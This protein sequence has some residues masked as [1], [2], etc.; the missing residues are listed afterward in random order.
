[1]GPPYVP[2]GKKYHKT[3][4]LTFNNAVGQGQGM[5]PTY[6]PQGRTKSFSTCFKDLLT[7]YFDNFLAQPQIIQQPGYSVPPGMTMGQFGGQQALAPQN[8]P[9]GNY[10][11]RQKIRF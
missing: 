9:P 3:F 4:G 6:V 7:F 5:A 11:E 10:I 1:M 2:Q 8:L